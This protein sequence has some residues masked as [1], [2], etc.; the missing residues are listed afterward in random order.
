[1]ELSGVSRMSGRI[2]TSAKVAVDAANAKAPGSDPGADKAKLP[3]VPEDVK[4]TAEERGAKR[5]SPPATAQERSKTPLSGERSK[6]PVTGEAPK[7]PEA[8]PEEAPAEKAPSAKA[9]PAKAPPAPEASPK[10]KEAHKMPATVRRPAP[11]VH[12][13]EAIPPWVVAAVIT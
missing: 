13:L 3:G 10:A 8:A 1:P 6:T 11:P 2:G 9:P 5:S 7:Q 4:I 12:G